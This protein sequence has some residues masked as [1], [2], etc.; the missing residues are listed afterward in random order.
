MADGQAPAPAQDVKKKRRV[1]KKAPGAQPPGKVAGAKGAKVK[2]PGKPEP[3]AR[4]PKLTMHDRQYVDYI[5]ECTV[6]N[7]W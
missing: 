4:R 2:F 7:I 5:R 1:K 3:P 6:K